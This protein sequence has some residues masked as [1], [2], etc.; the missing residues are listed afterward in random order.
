MCQ[1]VH[2]SYLKMPV[3]SS[4]LASLRCVPATQMDAD[5][6]RGAV[7]SSRRRPDVTTPSHVYIREALQ[8]GLQL[9]PVYHHCR[10]SPDNGSAFFGLVKKHQ[11]F[12]N[13]GAPLEC[14][15]VNNPS[16][17]VIF[18][19]S[20]KFRE[21]MAELKATAEELCNEGGM[22]SEVDTPRA[23]LKARS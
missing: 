19:W 10:K 2:V 12:C 23:V 5:I 20:E 6:T 22:F 3:L 8:R 21:A 1:G 15:Q 11:V 7:M 14:P 18:E 17:E 13:T 9:V 16:N 4:L